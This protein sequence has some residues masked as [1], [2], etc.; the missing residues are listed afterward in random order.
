M[1]CPQ[2]VGQ[3]ILL[4]G[5]SSVLHRTKSFSTICQ[6][7]QGFKQKKQVKI[8]TFV[9]LLSYFCQLFS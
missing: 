1:Y 9:R 3:E 5:F 4:K 2:K 7:Y 8:V 6:G